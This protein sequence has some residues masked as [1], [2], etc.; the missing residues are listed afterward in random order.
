MTLSIILLLT[1][2]QTKTTENIIHFS[3]HW[4]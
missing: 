2:I 3:G 1:E 4:W